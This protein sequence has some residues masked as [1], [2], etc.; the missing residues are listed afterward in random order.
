MDDGTGDGNQSIKKEKISGFVQKGPFVRG[1][2]ILMSELNSELAQTGKVFTSQI[3][4][5]QGLFE[6]TNIE[7]NSSFVEF[8]SS[9]F[10]FNE[11]TGEI[12]SAPITLTSISDL[13]NKSSINVNVLTHLEKKRVENLI[14]EGKSFSEAKKQAKNEVLSIFSIVLDSNSDFE[15]YDISKNTEEGGILLAISIILQGNRSVGQLTELLSKIQSDIVTDG[16]LDEVALLNSLRVSTLDLNLADIRKKIEAR[17]KELN[18]TSSFPDFEKH[19]TKFLSYRNYLLEVEIIGEGT[20]EEKI[21]TN[22]SG[23]EYPYK[24]VVQLTPVP[25]EGWVFESW[26]GDLSG[27]ESPKTIT[28][29]KEKKVTVKFKKRDYLLNINIEGEGTVTEEIISSPS[30]REYPFQTIVKLTPIAKEGWVFESWGGDLSGTEPSKT[31]T[32]DKEKN[33]TVKFKRKDY[34]L[35]IIIEGEGSVIEEIISNPSGREYPF[36]TGVKLTPVPK[37][38]WFFESWSGDLS[39][40]E[41]SKTISMD[42]EK[43]IIIRFRPIFRLAENGITCICE[44]VKPGEKGFINGIEF[45]A[46]DNQLL[47]KRKDEGRDLTK[48]CTSLVT[49]LSGLFQYSD[50]NQPIGNWDVS[51]VAN[52]SYTFDNSS[53]NQPI[54][55]WDVSNVFEMRLMFRNSQFNQSL[56]NWNVKNVRT[57]ESMFDSTKFNKPIRSWDVGNVQNMFKMFSSSPFNQ[58]IGSWDV[59]NVQNMA[60]M[61]DNTPFNHSIENWDVSNVTN[62]QNMFSYSQFN[63]PIGNWDVSKVTN[64]YGMF[65]SSPFNNSLGNWDVSRVLDMQRMFLNSKFNENIS[66]WCVFIQKIEPLEFS[67]NSPLSPE[68]KPK[69]GTCPD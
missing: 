62:M 32:V 20:V 35:N 31:I 24:T 30:G 66:S 26:G 19:I 50:F 16:K 59:G 60:A 3:I 7:L 6:I 55:Q 49:D 42:K 69:W 29:D 45:E 64:M 4:N 43:T 65:Q 67:L 68:N 44:N 52:M 47:R 10:Y 12:S 1:T 51:N 40:N 17:N 2:S 36:Q 14:K 8:S 37:A 18:I 15:D 34:T 9:G 57:M 38:G 27:T 22:P 13:S 28:V 11:V 48:L 56:E 63:Q 21:V 46:V 58:D 53:F 33:V 41:S 39:G 25:K 23:K 61:F 54:E 5:D